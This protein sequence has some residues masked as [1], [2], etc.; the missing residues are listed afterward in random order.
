[1]DDKREIP[2]YLNEV[3][4]IGYIGRDPEERGETIQFSLATDSEAT[5]KTGATLKRTEWHRIVCRGAARDQARQFKKGSHVVVFGELV[6][7]EYEKE[8]EG[9]KIPVRTWE[10]HAAEVNAGRR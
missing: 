3:I 5:S 4:V 9:L 8:V 7:R 10:I 1:M 2:E 6:S